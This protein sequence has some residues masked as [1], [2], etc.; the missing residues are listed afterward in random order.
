MNSL[1]VK[2]GDTVVLLT[3]KFADKYS[4]D[5]GKVSQEVQRGA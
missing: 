2:K 5:N 1:H 3:G 4:D